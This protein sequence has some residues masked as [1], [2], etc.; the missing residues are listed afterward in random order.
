MIVTLYSALVRSHVEYCVQYRRSPV[1]EGCGTV[2]VGPKEGHEDYQRAGSFL[3]STF[4]EK[5]AGGVGVVQSGKEK[6]LGRPHCCLPVLEG[7]L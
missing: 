4:Y 6:A 2:G 7:S 3:T 5:K 1:Q